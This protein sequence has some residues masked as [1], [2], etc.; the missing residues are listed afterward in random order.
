MWKYGLVHL[1]ILATLYLT[2]GWL[3]GLMALIVLVP[4]VDVVL[5]KLGYQRMGYGDLCMSYEM[6]R[7]NHN[8]GG[9][10]VMDKIDFKT[11]QNHIY[12]TGI[13]HVRKLS[14]IQV[15]K[16]GFKLWKDVGIEVGK[17]QIRK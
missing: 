14:Q 6:P 7:I 16:Y 3:Y 13:K 4:L 12:E 15:E 9:F 1:T 8:V 5:D 2:L 11:F 10:F 17:K